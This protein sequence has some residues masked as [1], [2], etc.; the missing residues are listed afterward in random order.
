MHRKGAQEWFSKKKM[1]RY[2]KPRKRLL[3]PTLVGQALPS[4]APMAFVGDRLSPPPAIP[5]LCS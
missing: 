4:L 2:R 1:K 3:H 5:D